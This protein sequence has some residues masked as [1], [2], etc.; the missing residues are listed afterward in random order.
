[1]NTEPGGSIIPRLS[2]GVGNEFDLINEISRHPQ[3]SDRF[4]PTLITVYP[5]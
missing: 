2:S 4:V 1:M 3:E 5:L